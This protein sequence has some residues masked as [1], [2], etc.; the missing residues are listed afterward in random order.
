MHM[1]N[2]FIV[3]TKIVTHFTFCIFLLIKDIVLLSSFIPICS[4][5]QFVRL[6]K[7]LKLTSQSPVDSSLSLRITEGVANCVVADGKL[8]L[9]V[10]VLPALEVELDD[11]VVEGA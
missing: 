3:I 8:G 10:L 9:D 6:I 1:L 5:R 7:L 2:T 4:K 11:L